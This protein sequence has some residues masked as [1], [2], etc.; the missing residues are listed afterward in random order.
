M[1]LY[2]QQRP[3][4]HRHGKAISP[5]HKQGQQETRLLALPPWSRSNFCVLER[6]RLSLCAAAPGSLR[7]SPSTPSSFHSLSLYALELSR[8]ESTSSQLP[9]SPES[10]LSPVVPKQGA[11]AASSVMRAS[12]AALGWNYINNLPALTWI[13]KFSNLLYPHLLSSYHKGNNSIPWQHLSIQHCHCPFP[14]LCRRA[15]TLFGA[16]FLHLDA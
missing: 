7:Q 5:T 15:P 13:K 8:P 14:Q 12:F 3:S 6:P 9:S 4:R 16:S 11:S 2:D 1:E 10:H